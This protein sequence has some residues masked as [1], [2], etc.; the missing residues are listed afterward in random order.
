MGL[1]HCLQCYRRPATGRVYRGLCPDCR[2]AAKGAADA[3]HLPTGRPRLPDNP[4]DIPRWSIN[5]GEP[6]PASLPAH[7]DRLPFFP[8]AVPSPHPQ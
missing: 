4:D 2:A 1:T 8:S 6:V 7:Q 5:S 3:N